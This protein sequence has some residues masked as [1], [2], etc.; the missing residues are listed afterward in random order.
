MY[1]QNKLDTLILSMG[2][3]QCIDEVD[4]TMMFA[5]TFT[6]PFFG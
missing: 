4:L 5:T 3:I 1:V 6:E 2:Y